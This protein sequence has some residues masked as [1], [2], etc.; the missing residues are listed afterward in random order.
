[1]SH[2]LNTFLDYYG[3]KIEDTLLLMLPFS[4]KPGTEKFNEAINYAVFPSGKRM[5][6]FF[7][8]LAAKTVGGNPEEAIPM[9]CAIEYFHTCSLIFDDLP[10]MDNALERRGR[11][12]IHRVFGEDVAILA[13]LA[14]LNQGYAIAAQISFIKNHRMKMRRL[15]R[16]ITI[17][18]GP[19]GMIGGQFLDLWLKKDNDEKLRSESYFKTT[20]LMRLM[21]VVGAMIGGGNDNQINALAGIGEKLGTAY[22]MLDDIVDVIEDCGSPEVL[23]VEIDIKILW[24]KA[25]Q[26]LEDVHQKLKVGI[27][28]CSPTLLIGFVDRI[29]GKI[30]KQAADIFKENKWCYVPDQTTTR[31]VAPRKR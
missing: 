20:S 11:Q 14:F 30:Q 23:P 9:A 27:A 12:P 25:K 17:C 26:N 19:N 4:E 3:R 6:P 10:A 8:L 24:Q 2:T 29:F 5:R 21:L 13:A 18:I 1:M 28:D 16:E 15:M 22:Q 7:T 31:W